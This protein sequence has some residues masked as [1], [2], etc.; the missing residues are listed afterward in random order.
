MVNQRVP[1]I[2]HT[3]ARLV[4]DALL[5]IEN[6][7]DLF[8]EPGDSLDPPFAPRPHLGRYVV[9]CSYAQFLRVL[10][11]PEIEPRVVYKYEQIWSISLQRTHRCTEYGAYMSQISKHFR[12]SHDSLA[13]KILF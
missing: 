12:E 4:I 13:G 6:D 7:Q 2:L 9:D 8:G 1:D 5:E 10:R 3:D 11:Q